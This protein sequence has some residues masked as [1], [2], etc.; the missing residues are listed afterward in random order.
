VFIKTIFQQNLKVPVKEATMLKYNG[1]WHAA[2]LVF[3]KKSDAEKAVAEMDGRLL[4]NRP[5]K[6]SIQ[7]PR[8]EAAPAAAASGGGGGGG[9]KKARM[10]SD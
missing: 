10:S 9:R 6:V 4:D 7:V 5:M 1:R 8:G 2:R 3:K